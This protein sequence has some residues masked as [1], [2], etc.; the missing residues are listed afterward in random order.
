[1][2]KTLIVLGLLVSCSAP[3]VSVIPAVIDNS[4]TGSISGTSDSS[5]GSI[6]GSNDLE[7][8][9]GLGESDMVFSPRLDLNFLSSQIS[10]SNS[11][12]SFSG[13]GTLVED[14]GFDDDSPNFPAGSEVDTALDLN[15]TSLLW[16]YNF[17]NTDAAHFGLGLG[18]SAFD[19]VFN[20]ET[21]IGALDTDVRWPV[22]LIGIRAGGDLGVVRLAASLATL[23]VAA[24]G[25]E[26]SFTDLD[27]YAGIDVIGDT[28]GL[29]L[30]YRSIDI[31][32]AYDDGEASVAMELGLGGPYFGLRL[33]F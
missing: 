20:M 19:F 25:G 32:A 15:A 17:V 8:D 6:P 4:L 3:S 33:S 16:T 11:S 21:D 29:V 27:V 10:V 28:G 13:S 22:P 12:P 30:G 23:Q 18:I 9:L 24:N 14:M 2:K 26:I 7:D 5:L 1:M 31:E